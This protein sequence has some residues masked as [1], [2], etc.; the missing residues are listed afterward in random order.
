ML[1]TPY[2]GQLY[3]NTSDNLNNVLAQELYELW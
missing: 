2:N 1:C 3:A